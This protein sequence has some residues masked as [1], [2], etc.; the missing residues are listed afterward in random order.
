MLAVVISLTALLVWLEHFL[1]LI[2]YVI[3][4]VLKDIMGVIKPKLVLNV[5]MIASVATKM[6]LV[7]LVVILT[8]E[9]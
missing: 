6:E 9:H 2:T 1:G 8:S 5:P 7:L 3:T 4:V